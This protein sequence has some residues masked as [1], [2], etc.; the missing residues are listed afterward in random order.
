MKFD[1]IMVCPP[2]KRYGVFRNRLIFG[3]IIPPKIRRE[4]DAFEFIDHSL[5]NFTSPDH[6]VF[7]WAKKKN[8]NGY[9]SHMFQ[10]GYRARGSMT[11]VR[12]KWK[13]GNNGKTVEF[14]MIFSKGNMPILTDEYMNMSEAV[15]TETI[16]ERTAKPQEAYKLLE[17]EFPTLRKLQVYGWTDRP[18]WTVFHRNDD[19]IK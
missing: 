16:A 13:I 6:L 5:Q 11:W 19:K 1:I 18:G 14:L 4:L 7:V 12:P 10:L 8:V 15:F 3:D 9:R 17:K 2:W